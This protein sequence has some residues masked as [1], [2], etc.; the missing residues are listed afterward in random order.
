MGTDDPHGARRSDR[1]ARRYRPDDGGRG[2][3]KT[4][5]EARALNYPPE[6][7]AWLTAVDQPYGGDA[8]A[9]AAK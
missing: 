3:P 1:A 9:S 7:L 5:D 6:A 8:P 4:T 2:M